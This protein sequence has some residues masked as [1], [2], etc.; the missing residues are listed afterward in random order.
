[1]SNNISSS[2]GGGGIDVKVGAL[3]DGTRNLVTGN[4]TDLNG[5]VGITAMCPGTVTNNK[6]SGN[7]S[8]I[9]DNYDIGLGCRT[10]NNQ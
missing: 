9:W 8:G 7:G 5:L 4:I 10:S 6:S 3:S 2:N 1:V